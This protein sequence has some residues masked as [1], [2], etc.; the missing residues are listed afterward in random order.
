MKSNQRSIT[1]THSEITQ[2]EKTIIRSGRRQNFVLVLF[3]VIGVFFVLSA[4]TGVFGM[5]AGSV[6]KIVLCL[7]AI[8]VLLFSLSLIYRKFWAIQIPEGL[9]GYKS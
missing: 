9:T 6:V 3:A 2:A 1:V 8:S 7:A 4:A 5:D